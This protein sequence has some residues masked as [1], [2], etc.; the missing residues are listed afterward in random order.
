MAGQNEIT[1]LTKSEAVRIVFSTTEYK[2]TTYV[3][4]REYLTTSTYAGFTKKGIRLDSN[5]LDEFIEKLLEVKAAL[6]K[7]KDTPEAD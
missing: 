2:G 7:A 5:K 1:E 3:D 6:P 4:I